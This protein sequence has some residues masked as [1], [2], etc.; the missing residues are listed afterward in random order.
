MQGVACLARMQASQPVRQVFAKLS[1]KGKV[2]HQSRRVL[3]FQL[4]SPN[5]ALKFLAKPARTGGLLQRVVQADLFPP[6]SISKCKVV[7]NNIGDM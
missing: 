5:K 3:R 4:T 7:P 2:R 1:I 6:A